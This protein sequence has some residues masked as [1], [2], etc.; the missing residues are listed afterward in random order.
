MNNPVL[1]VQWLGTDEDPKDIPSLN[2]D[3]LQHS[4]VL[5]KQFTEKD[6]PEAVLSSLCS[7]VHSDPQFLY[8]GSHGVKDPDNSL[9]GIGPNGTNYLA[10]EA[11]TEVLTSSSIKRGYD[12]W[13]GACSSS[14]LVPHLNSMLNTRNQPKIRDL[15]TFSQNIGA[16]VCGDVLNHLL[17][18]ILRV[19]TA[20][21]IIDGISIQSPLLLTNPVEPVLK[22]LRNKGGDYKHLQLFR[23]LNRKTLEQLDLNGQAT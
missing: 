3:W 15:I 2:N 12:L 22:S 21:S 17:S 20:S 11:L 14:E 13:V 23:P 8:F 7:W 19:G 18:T 16:T 5:V 4:S 6:R 9:I 1:L 10:I